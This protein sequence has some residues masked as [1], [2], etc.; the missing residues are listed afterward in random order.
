MNTLADSACGS[1][2]ITP[3]PLPPPPQSKARYTKLNKVGMDV[4]K[5]EI[6]KKALNQAGMPTWDVQGLIIT[7]CLD[8][9]A[10]THSIQGKYSWSIARKNHL[11]LLH[12]IA[13][14]LSKGASEIGYGLH[15][16]IWF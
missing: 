16:D 2:R 15:I 14:L 11:A 4:A 8:T 12:N 9:D 6:L 3:P 10:H 7:A 5:M 1:Q 13:K